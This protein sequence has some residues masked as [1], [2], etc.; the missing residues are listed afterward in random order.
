VLGPPRSG[1]QQFFSKV[2]FQRFVQF[3]T[4]LLKR[5]FQFSVFQQRFLFECIQQLGGVF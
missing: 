3:C 4:F 2:Q 1:F 5:F